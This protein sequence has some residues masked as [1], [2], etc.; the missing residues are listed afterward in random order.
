MKNILLLSIL[1]VALISC[2]SET[3]V[4]EPTTPSVAKKTITTNKSTASDGSKLNWLTIDD[5]DK[6]DPKEGKKILVDVYTDWCGWCK[7]MDKN[8]FSNPEVI[9]HL[10]ENFHVIKFNAEQKESITFNGNT[11]NFKASGR[12][13]YNELAAEMLD[14]RLS[15]P[16][17][18]YFD[19]AKQKLISIPGYKKPD[20]L[21]SDIQRVNQFEN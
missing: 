5:L 17:I 15:Y 20:Q 7:V 11:Y 16:S 1:V 2:K 10:E 19:E 13:G 12:R 8:T 3:E 18:V 9:A 4:A 21:L 6:I 14:G